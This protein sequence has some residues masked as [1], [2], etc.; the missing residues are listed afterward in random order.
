MLSSSLL[1]GLVVTLPLAGGENTMTA[2][3][4]PKVH[5]KWSLL[6]PSETWTQVSGLIAI[7]HADGKGFATAKTGPVTLEVDT[8]ADGKY[9][10]KVKGSKGFVILKGK[11]A[12]GNAFRY[13]VRLRP[14]GKTYEFTCSSTMSGKINGVPIHLLDLNNNGRFDEVGKGGM[15]V[16]KSKGASF[17]SKVINLKGELFNLEVS[18]SGQEIAASP[19][20]GETG[21]LDLR[22]GFKSKGKLAFAVVSNRAGDISFNVAD[23]RKGMVVPV[24]SYHISGGRA[25]K[26]SEH[27]TLKA[28]QMADMIVEANGTTK[29]E[30]GMPVRA[31]IEFENNNGEIGVEPSKVH[32]IGAAGEEYADWVPDGASPKLLIKDA[33]TGKLL[34]S[35][36]FAGC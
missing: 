3:L 24:G 1:L 19:Y 16:G 10:A 20:E 11:D 32:Y 26:G 23:A 21:T 25:E 5:K 30:W 12:N 8:D 31:E 6:S 27:A 2:K 18:E 14:K 35:G 17:L 13:G 36:R 4:S 29:L 33:K 22:S 34:E 28:G 15:I 7:P 9:D